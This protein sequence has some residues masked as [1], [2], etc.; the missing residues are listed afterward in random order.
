LAA[1]QATVS[2]YNLYMTFPSS[3]SLH[4]ALPFSPTALKTLFRV[5]DKAKSIYFKDLTLTCEALVSFLMSNR[6]KP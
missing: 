6:Q 2:V 4:P 1:S 3:L 5:N